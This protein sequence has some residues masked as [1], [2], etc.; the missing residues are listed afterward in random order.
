MAGFGQCSTSFTYLIGAKIVNKRFAFFDQHNRTVVH[1][2]KIIRGKIKLLPFKAEPLH[3]FLDR[4]DVFRIFLY[5]V[6]IIETQMRTAFEFICQRKVNPD[7]LRMPDMQISV[8]FRRK[9]CYDRINLPAV[10]VFGNNIFDKIW[11][12]AV[13]LHRYQP[14]HSLNICL[15]SPI[16][17]LL[18]IPIYL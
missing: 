4:I 6:G 3:V 17:L 5:R 9:T 18:N 7:R 15:C 2:F 11:R 10:N 8:W 12:G 13:V 1:L 16:F 14:F